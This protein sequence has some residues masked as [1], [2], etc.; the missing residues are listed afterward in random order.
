MLALPLALALA[1]P[2]FGWPLAL[3]VGVGVSRYTSSVTVITD[4]TCQRT[5]LVAMP[6]ARSMPSIV[7][8]V[9]KKTVILIV[10]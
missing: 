9:V 1:L 2:A 7:F 6:V 8:V 3:G 10:L 4:I 5:E